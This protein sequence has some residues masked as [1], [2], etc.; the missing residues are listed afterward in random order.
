MYVNRSSLKRA[1]N[2]GNGSTNSQ[3]PDSAD[4]VPYIGT[5][6]GTKGSTRTESRND[7]TSLRRRWIIEVCEK[8]RLYE[9]DVAVLIE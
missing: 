6:K 2:N 1:S 7:P 8:T 5:S 3:S 4:R 9:T